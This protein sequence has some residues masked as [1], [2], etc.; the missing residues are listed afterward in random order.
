VTGE[1]QFETKDPLSEIV[2]VL[3]HLCLVK[4]EH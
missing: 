2:P 3:L 4:L 1:K